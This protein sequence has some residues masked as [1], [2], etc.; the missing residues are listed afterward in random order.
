MD[1]FQPPM[2][3]GFPVPECQTI[4][5]LRKN[6]TIF[7]AALDLAPCCS[8]AHPGRREISAVSTPVRRL[9]NSD[10]FQQFDRKFFSMKS[11]VF[12]GAHQSPMYCISGLLPNLPASPIFERARFSASCSNHEVIEDWVFFKAGPYSWLLANSS[13]QA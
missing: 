4:S 12:T 2:E 7:T 5:Q 13:S 6:R 1:I 9:G 10:I 8:L 11:S 3:L